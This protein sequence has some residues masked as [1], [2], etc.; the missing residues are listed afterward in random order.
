M[1]SCLSR[2]GFTTIEVIVV[3]A[4]LGI[5][6]LS[7][8]PA[9]LNT[10]ETRNLENSTRDILTTLQL[11]RFRSIDTKINHRVRFYQ[12]DGGWRFALEWEQAPDT[13]TTPPRTAVNSISSRFIVTVD[14]PASQSVE[15][16]SIGFI[17][18]YDS[19]RNSIILQSLKLK[20][21]NQPDLRT[22]QVLGGGSIRN[23]KSPSG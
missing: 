9:I 7:S 10:M 19:T 5:L 11:A 21:K 1:K 13:W 14:L 18:G 22:L 20:S 17:E 3:V 23:L 15:Y 2:R 16:S 6:I 8:Y 4:I 12:Q